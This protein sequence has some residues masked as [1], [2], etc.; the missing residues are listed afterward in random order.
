MSTLRRW[1]AKLSMYDFVGISN[2]TNLTYFSYLFTTKHTRYISCD[3]K[4]KRWKRSWL[5]RMMQNGINVPVSTSILTIG[6]NIVRAST[7]PLLWIKCSQSINK[8]QY[9]VRINIYRIEFCEKCFLDNFYLSWWL[10][11]HQIWELFVTDAFCRTGYY[12]SRSA[13]SG[14]SAGWGH[15]HT[16]RRGYHCCWANHAHRRYYHACW[17][18]WGIFRLGESEVPV[19]YHTSHLIY[20]LPCCACSLCINY[21]VLVDSYHVYT[22]LFQNFFTGARAILRLPRY[23]WSSPE[24]YG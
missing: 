24:G 19:R 22:Q 3:S 10:T 23:Q 1:W 17:A 21:E 13:N 4:N 6:E 15:H 16:H 18:D 12:N 9:T 20:A 2:L 5:I 7:S 14:H 8:W 11:K